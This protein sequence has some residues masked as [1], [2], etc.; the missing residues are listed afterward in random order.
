MK[1]AEQVGTKMIAEGI[2]RL[3]ELNYL[4]Q[5]GIHYAQGYAL[6]KPKMDIQLGGIQVSSDE[7]SGSY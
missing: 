5:M 7:N 4:Q 1:Y 2:E 3:E 6:G